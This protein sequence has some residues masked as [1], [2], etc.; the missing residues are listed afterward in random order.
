MISPRLSDNG[1]VLQ[2]AGELLFESAP[3]LLATLEDL[4]LSRTDVFDVSA[5]TH[6]DSAGLAALLALKNRWLSAEKVSLRGASPQLV[7]LVEVTGV[8]GI[9]ATG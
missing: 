7:S 1:S 3:D 4:D 6:I 2:L 9:L 5:V 8:G